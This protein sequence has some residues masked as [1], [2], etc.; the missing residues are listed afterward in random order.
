MSH[1]SRTGGQSEIN[2]GKS[3]KGHGKDFSFVTHSE[4]ENLCLRDERGMVWFSSSVT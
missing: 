3:A 1:L 2:H 4:L